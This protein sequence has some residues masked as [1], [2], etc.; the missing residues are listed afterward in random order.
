MKA[1]DVHTVY[2]ISVYAIP[3]LKEKIERLLKQ[4]RKEQEKRAAPVSQKEENERS[5]H[6]DVETES[7]DEGESGVQDLY[8]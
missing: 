7:E 1:K 3:D 8:S 4:Q 5:H 2:D 6:T